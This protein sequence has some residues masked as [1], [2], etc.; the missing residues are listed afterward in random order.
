MCVGRS[1]LQL[2]SQRSEQ[3]DLDL[4]ANLSIWTVMEGRKTDSSSTCIPKGPADA[5]FVGDRRALEE[6]RCLWIYQ[7]GSSV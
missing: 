2:D 1:S 4:F 7:H 3:N 5:I 6:S